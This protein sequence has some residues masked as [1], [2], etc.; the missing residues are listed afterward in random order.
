MDLERNVVSE[1]AYECR[2]IGYGVES[3]VIPAFW[4]G[5]IDTW[6]KHTIRPIDGSPTLYLFRDEIIAVEEL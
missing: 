5:E 2:D 1:I 6:G 4:T 3:G